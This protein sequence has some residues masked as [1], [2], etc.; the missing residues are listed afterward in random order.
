VVAVA[1]AVDR[2]FLCKKAISRSN[3]TST[4]RMNTPRLSALCGP[5]KSTQVVAPARGRSK[6]AAK[7]KKAFVHT[8]PF[9]IQAMIEWLEDANNFNIIIGESN[10]DQGMKHGGGV[11]K[12]T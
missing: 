12:I 7:P 9:Q 8:T 3:N 1:I 6:N 10:T 4:S 5:R 11:S 2:D